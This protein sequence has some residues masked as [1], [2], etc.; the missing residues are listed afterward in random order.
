MAF[1]I[2]SLAIGNA[3]RSVLRVHLAL[4]KELWMLGERGI[5]LSGVGRGVRSCVMW[6]A[7]LTNGPARTVCDVASSRNLTF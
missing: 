4:Q 3:R 2:Q 1:V 5:V 6:L 7:Q